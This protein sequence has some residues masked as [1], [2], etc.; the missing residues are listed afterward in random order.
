MVL[1][2]FGLLFSKMKESIMKLSEY[3]LQGKVL[4]KKVKLKK[5]I[6]LNNGEIRKRGDIVSLLMENKDGTFHAEDNEWA[7]TV[8]RSEFEMI[9][10]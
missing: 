4:F 3:L 9:K 8:N 10:E 1:V 7:C 6:K 5:D 2:K